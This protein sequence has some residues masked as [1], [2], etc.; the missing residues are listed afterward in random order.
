[1][2]TNFLTLENYS[3][4]KASFAL[5]NYV[6]NIVERNLKVAKAEAINYLYSPSLLKI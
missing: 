2:E 3:A 4:Y 6:W 1:M 5:S